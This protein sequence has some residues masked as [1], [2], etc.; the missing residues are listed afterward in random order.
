MKFSTPLDRRSENVHVLTIVI[1]ELEFGDIERHI[2]AAHFVER[3]DHAALEYR[4]KA[5]NGLGVD[6]T[7][8]IL[9]F[10]MIS[11]AM[12]IFAVEPLVT[13]PL[14]GAKQTDFAGDSFA[15]K[16]RESVRSDI[17]DHAGDDIALAADSA[18][19]WCFAGTDASGPAAAAFIPMSVFGQAPD[20]SFID[21][22]NAAELINVL[23]ESGSDLV[24]H[25]PCSLIGTEAHITIKLQSAHAFLANEHQVNDAIPI[26]KRF[27][28]VLENR[29]GNDGE[30]IGDAL[31][32]VHAF[33]LKAMVLS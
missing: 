28:G 18:D 32:A 14:I 30:S 17:R 8:D 16:R 12:R 11:D 25:E 3:A 20:E 22:D 29:P 21:C 33:P 26:A 10:G 5:L 27:V 6:C 24:A 4:P 19:D 2:F 1:S 15:D 7:D 23:H 9:P 13:W 31:S